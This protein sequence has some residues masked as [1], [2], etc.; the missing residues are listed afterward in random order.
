M[1]NTDSFPD[2]PGFDR[3]LLPDALLEFVV[4]GDTHY[5]L[6][7]EPYAVEFGSVREWPER[8]QWALGLAASLGAEQGRND[9]PKFGFYLV[10]VGAQDSRV[11]LIR[12]GGER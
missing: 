11:H 7:P 3:C 6:D 1:S 5:I 2:L 10:R 8:A 4:I 12:T 9:R